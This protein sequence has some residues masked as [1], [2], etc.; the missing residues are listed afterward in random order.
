MCCAASCAAPCAM[1]SCSAPREPLMWQLVPA[2][3]REMGQAYPELVRGE[4]LITETLKLEET[5]FRKTL[6]RGLGLLVG[7]DGR[8]GRRRHAGRRDRLQALRHLRLPARSDAGRAAPARHLGR[9]RRLHRMR[10]SARRPKRASSWAG[11]GE[12]AT[13]TVW[14]AVRE[15][16]GATEF[17]GYD[18]EAGRRHRAGAG[19]GRQGRRQR[20]ARATTVGDRRQP[21]A[22]L[23]RVRRPDGRHRRRSPA[24]ASRSRLPTRRRRPTACSCISA[25]WRAARSRPALPSS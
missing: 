6:A 2:L 13:E 4:A 7:G 18:T 23:W 8:P 17:L 3:V 12:A 14:F 25:R 16:A 15:K 1:R 20:P 9:S 24:T 5:R 19:Q 21:D 11:S 22:V 10:W